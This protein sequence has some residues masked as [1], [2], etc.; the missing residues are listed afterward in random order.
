MP[1]QSSSIS[2]RQVMPAGATLTPGSLTRPLTEKLLK[3][4]EP[5][6]PW[7]ANQAGPF[8]AMSRIQNRVSTLL[9]R[10]GRPK[11]PTSAT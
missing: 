7:E 11:M 3:P 10:V 2:S 5:C 1:P 4:F 6:R 9:T 8:S